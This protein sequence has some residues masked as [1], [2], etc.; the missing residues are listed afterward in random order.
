MSVNFGKSSDT[1]Y[2]IFILHQMYIRLINNSSFVNVK[3]S[4]YFYINILL[5]VGWKI[6]KHVN[7][8]TYYI[9][10]TRCITDRPYVHKNQFS[11]V[12][13]SSCCEHFI[14]VSS[15]GLI[16]ED[17]FSVRHEFH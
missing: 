2:S 8:T 5:K 14:K 17:Q 1:E 7:I 16:K 4:S 13:Y 15:G 3:K 11:W 10:L 6:T 9:S 12:V